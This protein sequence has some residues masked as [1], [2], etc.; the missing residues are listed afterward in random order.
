MK[1]VNL[2]RNDGVN[3]DDIHKKGFKMGEKKY[4]VY[5][6]T[7][8]KGKVYVGCTSQK[9]NHRF[10]RNGNGYKFS[11][12]LY[13]DI[14]EF[15]WDSFEHEVVS[16]D[17]NE[18]EAYALEKDMIHS[19]EA[20]NPNKGYNVSIGGKGVVGQSGSKHPM[21]GKRHTEES[22]RK[23]S[24]SHIG[25]VLSEETKRRISD[26]NK[27]RVVSEYQRSRIIEANRNRI[28]TEESKQKNRDA[29]L[30]RR[31]TE[32]TK[33]KMS[34]SRK[35]HPTSE[36]TRQKIRIAN[37]GKH[38]TEETRIKLSTSHLGICPSDE[39]RIKMRKSN[40]NKKR[41]LCVETGIVYDSA[42]EAGRMTGLRKNRISDA[43]TGV[44]E[45]CGGYHWKYVD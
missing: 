7:S 11:K 12:E 15:G 14:E 36:E 17:L 1:N 24:E 10:G 21:Y 25:T 43:C 39:T 37:T 6:H 4:A 9:L 20:T 45:T 32:E 33:Q 8:P 16:S 28:I 42:S 34:E 23:M 38:P 35:G 13:K 5:K 40:P 19:L 3:G 2:T 29:H 27:G 44:S 30:G 26:A 41:T 22:R 31:H 18:D